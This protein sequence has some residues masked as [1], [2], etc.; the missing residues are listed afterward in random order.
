MKSDQIRD[1]QTQDN[2]IQNNETEYTFKN[3]PFKHNHSE[4]YE[5]Y[6]FINKNLT[7]NIHKINFVVSH[8]RCPDGC[9]S[10]TI[11]RMYLRDIGVD[12]STVTFIDGYYN[13]DYSKFP[14][15]MRNKFVLICDFSFPKFIF[16]KMIETTKGNILI[17]DHHKTAQ[18]SLQDVPAE[19]LVFDMNHSGA[20]ITW[21]YFFGFNNVP[22]A[23]LYVEDTDLWIKKLPQTKEYNAYMYSRPFDFDEYEK[24]FSDTY[25]IEEAF[26]KG[27]GIVIQ[28]DVCITELTKA[29]VPRF[30]Q[31][32]NGRYYFVACVNSAG[33]LRNDLGNFVI[34]KYKNINMSMIYAHNHFYNS[35]NISYRSLDDRSDST[36]ISKLSN[37]GGHRNASGASVPFI[38]DN[39]P[40]RVIDSHRAY[41]MLNDLYEINITSDVEEETCHTFIVMNSSTLSKHL[42][43]YLMQERFINEDGIVKNKTRT[44]LQLPGYQ[45][46]MFCM[47]NRYN[48]P[49]YDNVYTGAYIWHFDGHDKVYKIIV[50]LGANPSVF[51]PV[52]MDTFKMIDTN[53]KIIDMKDGLY[54]II[55]PMNITPEQCIKQLLF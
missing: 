37:G 16:D 15:M 13:S 5:T 50:K 9:M 36:E 23:V 28:N 21:T 30:I 47:R 7:P 31:I 40:G 1:N 52:S 34:E 44:S 6:D 27:A 45:E 46:G 29:C 14:E 54:K 39:P 11:V 48:N 17:L 8:G 19:Y 4:I 42:V 38:V 12:L 18:K 51:N 43:K 20:F 55:I 25:L 53:I 32:P 3:Y 22:K 10:A 49:T 24:F 2:Q 41:Y 35:T 33:L 26:P